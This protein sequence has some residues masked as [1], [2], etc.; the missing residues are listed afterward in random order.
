[1][2]WTIKQFTHH[3]QLNTY[4]DNMIAVAMH[5]V[6]F[7][8]N[9]GLMKFSLIINLNKIGPQQKQNFQCK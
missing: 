2:H 8:K 9:L 7:L 3:A 4:V 5:A 1:M 6:M